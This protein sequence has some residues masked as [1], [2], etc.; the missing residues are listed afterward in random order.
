VKSE[1][2]NLGKNFAFL[3]H[4]RDKSDV[5]RKFPLLKVFP[6]F[7]VN[8]LIRMLPP[9]PLSEIEGFKNK[10][11][12]VVRGFIIS[13]PLTSVQMLENRELA[14]KKIVQAVEYARDKKGVGLV[15]FGAL[16]ASLT[17]GG[18]KVREQVK[19]IS[20]TTGHAYTVKTVTDYVKRVI[21]DFDLD[22]SNV[23]I[24]II[25][26]AGSIGSGSA[27]V[28]YKYGVRNFLFV[29]LERKSERVKKHLMEIKNGSKE[30]VH[31]EISHQVSDIKD[32]D[33]VITATN[34]PEVLVKPGDL[35]P[36]TIII[37]D[38]QP[39][40][41]SPEVVKT[42][43]DVLVIEAGVVYTPGVN[44]NFN[45]GLA[46]R[47]ETFCCLGEVLVLMYNGHY[48]DYTL[49]ELD[50]NLIQKLEDMQEGFDI[51]PASYQNSQ[52]GY[53]T[54]EQISKVRDIIQEKTK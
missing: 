47:E 26:A 50:I 19:D 42:R 32:Y 2:S 7:I 11:G 8:F 33:I 17:H 25:G 4:P 54:K 28:L 36:G 27:K 52:Q 35:S 53:I 34:A 13:V 38:A 46:S 16:T 6:E 39:S 45:M 9:V 10:D 1:T 23:K 51:K 31:I 3:V 24:A 49:G 12:D 21:R 40:D 29:D 48:D 37:N 15:G 22:Q 18:L 5:F 41:V 30:D 20:I 44:Y 43:D 14:L